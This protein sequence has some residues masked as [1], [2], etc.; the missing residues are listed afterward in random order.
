MVKG[1][2]RVAG[3]RGGVRFLNLPEGLRRNSGKA[4]RNHNKRKLGE[5]CNTGVSVRDRTD[6]AGVVWGGD[7]GGG[8]CG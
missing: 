2:Q 7:V 1:A 4:D 5:G 8:V 6:G 3:A